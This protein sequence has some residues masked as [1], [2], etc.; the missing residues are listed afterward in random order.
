MEKRQEKRGFKV[1]FC[2]KERAKLYKNADENA[3]RKIR[4]YWVFDVSEQL[5]YD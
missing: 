2:M 1:N 5:I 4:K 3:I